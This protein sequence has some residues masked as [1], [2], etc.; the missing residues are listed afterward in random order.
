MTANKGLKVVMFD[1]D[2]T[3]TRG[4]S[5][6]WRRLHIRFGT[7]S[8]AKP[9]LER[10]F[11]NEITYQEWA[12]LDSMLWKGFSYADAVQVA[13]DSVILEGARE[14]TDALRSH[15]IHVG[16][17]SGG[18]DVMAYK[19]A[20]AMGIPHEDVY[21]NELGH[22]PET[23]LLTGTSTYSVLWDNKGELLTEFAHKKGVYDMS[24]V[25]FVGD[26]ENDIYAFRVAG[27]SV[28][29]NAT[30]DEVKQAA[31]AVLNGSEDLRDLLRFLLPPSKIIWFGESGLMSQ[32]GGDP[33]IREKLE[34]AKVDHVFCYPSAEAIKFLSEKIHFNEDNKSEDAGIIHVDDRLCKRIGKRPENMRPEKAALKEA[35]TGI[36][37]VDFTRVADIAPWHKEL[38]EPLESVK[39]RVAR[40]Q[41]EI[42]ENI[43]RPGEV[44]AVLGPDEV[45]SALAPRGKDDAP[46]SFAGF[47][48]ETVSMYSAYVPKVRIMLDGENEPDWEE[49]ERQ[50]TKLRKEIEVLMERYPKPGVY[51]GETDADWD[52]FYE[53]VNKVFDAE[54]GP[55]GD[56]IK[57]I[58]AKLHANEEEVRPLLE[59]LGCTLDTPAPEIA[60]RFNNYP[61][62][63][64]WT[65]LN[66]F[67]SRVSAAKQIACEIEFSEC[68]VTLQIVSGISKK[69]GME[70]ALKRLE[71]IKTDK[72]KTYYQLKEKRKAARERADKDEE[73]N[74]V[75]T[76]YKV[77]GDYVSRWSKVDVNMGYESNARGCSFED[78]CFR[79]ASKY[80]MHKLGITT[81]VAA[82]N[83]KWM[84]SAGETDIVL[85]DDTQTRV[86]AII[87][88]KACLFDMSIAYCQSAP[89]F[90]KRDGKEWLVLDSKANSRIKVDEDVPCFVVTVIPP[91]DYILGFDSNVKALYQTLIE[92]PE[93][94]DPLKI[95]DKLREVCGSNISPND[96]I[97]RYGSET[98]IVYPNLNN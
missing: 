10:F 57:E 42:V 20:D 69:A 86:L 84:D 25:G 67:N 34:L 13:T 65:S 31:K 5:S 85:L 58:R 24:R 46:Y 78:T 53:H 48:E 18:L 16:I 47:H 19:V 26:G 14:M 29:Y 43:L 59:M 97:K 74:K 91:H 62:G 52:A 2:G 51:M 15:G 11:R 44:C 4:T 77:L 68:P 56:V 72:L 61:R 98:L 28:A 66:T 17:L 93:Y 8:L 21:T 60:R 79:Y 96:W 63:S 36:D 64:A 82:R 73:Y 87:E 71:E 3:L 1:V 54:G 38:R 23:G 89:E 39:K 35:V 49:V 41:T 37:G 22:D 90:R 32:D 33:S 7:E 70:V 76:M 92:N 45:I 27:M 12:L 55:R 95:R 40:L 30:N 83:L 75:N 80:V 6:I 9:N 94:A 50:Q 81:C 88:C